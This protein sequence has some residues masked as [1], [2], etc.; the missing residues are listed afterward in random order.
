MG[1]ILRIASSRIVGQGD[2]VGRSG[3]FSL[4]L[5]ANS[6]MRGRLDARRTL[7]SLVADLRVINFLHDMLLV[8]CI[9][10]YK[11]FVSVRVYFYL[12][13][14]RNLLRIFNNVSF[15]NFLTLNQFFS[16]F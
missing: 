5:S 8:S 1:M 16:L 10:C 3:Y 12:L 15:D 9:A 2:I 6:V 13:L 4:N 7:K 11:L 14:L